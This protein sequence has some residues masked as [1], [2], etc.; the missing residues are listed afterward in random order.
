MSLY[1]ATYDI[2]DNRRRTHVAR[3][4]L[5]YGTRLQRSVFEVWL[6]PAE[7]DEFRREVG[8]LLA[9][10]DDFVLM[11]VDERGTRSTYSWQRPL[12]RFDAV[13]LV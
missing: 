2:S 13:I 6:E 10:A 8:V 4:L 11:P 7:L 9:V 5:Q 1:V 12:Q 3:V